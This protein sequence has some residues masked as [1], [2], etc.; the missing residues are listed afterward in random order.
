MGMGGRRV[1]G[2]VSLHSVEVK[3]IIICFR[4][5]QGFCSWG[6]GSIP[7]LPLSNGNSV[8]EGHIDC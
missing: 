4:L 5:L 3:V 8:S 1:V 6:G 2:N 7:H